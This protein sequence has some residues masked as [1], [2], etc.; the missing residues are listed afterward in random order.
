M[1]VCVHSVS[2]DAY[3]SMCRKVMN[4]SWWIQLKR[5]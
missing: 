4:S 2:L 3:K 5:S 1:N